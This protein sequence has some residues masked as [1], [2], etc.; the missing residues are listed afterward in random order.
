MVPQEPPKRNQQRLIRDHGAT[1][2]RE[3]H[4]RQRDE[5]QPACPAGPRW[6]NFDWPRGFARSRPT[7]MSRR[8][9]IPRASPTASVS[10]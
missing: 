10:S 3:A 7:T 4:Q 5:A 8:K 9:P 2:Y 1:A 6:A